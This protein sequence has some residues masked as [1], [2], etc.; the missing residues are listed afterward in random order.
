MQGTETPKIYV[1]CLASYNAGYLHGCWID[2]TLEIE[3]IWNEV[4]GMLAT[5][6]VAGAEEWALHDFE[7]FGSLRLSEFEGIERVHE[8][9]CFIEDN[10]EIGAHLLSYYCG[11]VDEAR[12]AMENYQGCFDDIADYAAQLAEECMEIP[13]HLE[14]YIDYG[15]MA[16]DME[17]NGEFFTIE[18]G[19]NE[20]H[21]FLGS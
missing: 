1:A 14:H 21:V 15:A 11:D 13:P 20:V 6:P 17:L 9:A 5:S 12:R 2:A 8:L 18:T 3:S 7:G 19:F 10:P 16:R 4:R